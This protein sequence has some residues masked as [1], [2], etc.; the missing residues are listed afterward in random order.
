[1]QINSTLLRRKKFGTIE[2]FVAMKKTYRSA[3]DSIFM[4]YMIFPR[5]SSSQNQSDGLG[6]QSLI[7]SQNAITHRQK[8]IT[9][10]WLLNQEIW[11]GRWRG[12]FRGDLLEQSHVFPTILG[13]VHDRSFLGLA[14]SASGR[15]VLPRGRTG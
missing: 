11:S 3:H 4:H 8:K 7:S 6:S 10:L 2:K 9:H 14:L 15:Q 12:W 5:F 13:H 1:M